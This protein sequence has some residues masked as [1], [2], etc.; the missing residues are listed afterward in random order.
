VTGI[1]EE[2]HNEKV[3]AGVRWFAKAKRERFV[4]A[5]LPEQQREHDADE[6][7]ADICG[8]ANAKQV[9]ASAKGGGKLLAIRMR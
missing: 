3:K 6:D 7:R 5:E 9:G 8:L 2:H 1:T 4:S